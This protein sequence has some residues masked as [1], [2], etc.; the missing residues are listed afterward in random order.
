MT[1]NPADSKFCK[2]C[3]T[4]LPQADKTKAPT[5]TIEAPKS[6]LTTGSTFAGRYQ[7]IEELGRGGM[8]RVYKVFDSKIKEKIALKLIKPDIAAD[9]STIE[10]FGNELKFSRK[11]SHRNVCRMFDIGEDQGNHY[12]TMEYVAGEDLKSMLRMMGRMSPA[13]TVS[14]ARQICEGLEEA[15]RLGIIHRDLKPNNIMIDREGS[16]RIMDFGIARSLK[17]KGMTG[18]G[19]MIGTPEYMSPEQ[20]EAKELDVTS[21]IYS[22]GVILYEMV[23]GELPF[24]GDTPLAVAMKHKGE[25]PQDPREI[26]AQVPEELS[27]LILRCLAK[28]RGDRY[29][30]AGEMRSELEQI[31]T[32]LPTTSKVIPKAIP[33]TS[34][35]ITVSFQPKR[36]LIPALA[37]VSVAVVV[38]VLLLIIPGKKSAPIPTDKPSLAVIYFENHSGN[39][40]LENWRSGLSEMLITDLSQSKF[41]HILSGDR[42]YSL[43]DDL[44]LIEKDKFS[45]DDLLRIASRGGVSH[46]LRGNFIEAGEQFIINASLM[47][48]D[49][50]EVISSIQ[51]KGLGESS[52]SDSVDRITT[53]IKSDL[54]LTKDQV[55]EDIDRELSQITTQSPEA[56]KLYAEGR[57]IF[58]TGDERASIPYFERAIAA[59]A[60]FALAYRSL[61][62]AYNNLGFLP[63]REKYTEKAMELSGRLPERD[64]YLIEGTYF[65]NSENTYDRAIPVYKKALEL[66]PDDTTINHNLAL[67]YYGMDEYDNAILYYERA[68]KAKTIFAGTYTQLANALRTTGEMDKALAVLETG[69][70]ITTNKSSINRG[71][72]LHFLFMGEEERALAAVE[73]ALLENPEDFL[74]YSTRGRIYLIQGKF[75]EA[76]EDYWL[77]MGKTEPGLRYNGLNGLIDLSLRQGQFESAKNF[78]L[79]GITLAT[80]TNVLWPEAEWRLTLAHIHIRAGDFDEALKETQKAY[81]VAVEADE[82]YLQRRAKHIEGL[83]HVYNNDLAQAELTARELK[84]LIDEGNYK[85]TTQLDHLQGEIDLKKGNYVQAIDAFQKAISLEFCQSN[86]LYST[87]LA[88]AYDLAGQTKKAQEEYIRILDLRTGIKGFGDLIS[89]SHLMLGV[90][91]KAQ[92]QNEAAIQNFEKFL[93]LWKDADPDLPEKAEAQKH[94]AS[95]EK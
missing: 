90:I 42:I 64:R 55:S 80:G 13:Q 10:R 44:G 56:Y 49:T 51:E 91:L 1:E 76:E 34:R 93:D 62:M 73:Q 40:D 66:Y 53:R 58:Y 9:K 63:M 27:V 39:E 88:Q 35:E 94:L 31:E 16:A 17:T 78:L 26:N 4:P 33:S 7:I 15:H 57:R 14:I 52:I 81:Q 95:L 36:L 8:G 65:T 25:T 69:L 75:K 77:L 61:A 74:P 28:N 24:R 22:L 50:A 32:G 41:L 46:I 12:I 37:V 79:R 85:N 70:K 2:E 20:A 6:E 3:A 11:I 92:G 68:V 72:A 83:A 21:D 47:K 30:S 89:K 84:N 86:A 29:L 82:P 5:R 60:D 59:D 23:T 48:G 18:S 87:S 38:L 54:D 43:L 19:I 45:T 71:M 67:I